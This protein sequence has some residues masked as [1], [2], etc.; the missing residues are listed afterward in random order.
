MFFYNALIAKDINIDIAIKKSSSEGKKVFVYLHRVG[1]SYCNSMQE[2]TI[3]DENVD[4]YIKENYIFITINVSLDDQIT[5]KSRKTTGLDFAK[6]IG[7]NFYPSSVFIGTNSEIVYATPGYKNE[8]EFL[9]LLEYV[10]YDMYDEMSYESYKKKI[11]YKNS[12]QNQIEDKRK[13]VR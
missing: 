9:S 10:K 1:C 3:E 5:Y 11:G 4:K 6:S 2:F 12:D 7:Y 13:H 8:L